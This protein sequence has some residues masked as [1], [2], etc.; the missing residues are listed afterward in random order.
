MRIFF[1]LL[2]L[3]FCSEK[4]FAQLLT[5]PFPAVKLLLVQEINNNNNTLIGDFVNVK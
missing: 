1:V 4:N 2:L 3:F 5:E